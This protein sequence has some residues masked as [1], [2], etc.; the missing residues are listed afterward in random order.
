M[1]GLPPPLSLSPSIFRSPPVEF[2]S[3]KDLRRSRGLPRNSRFDSGRFLRANR[4]IEWD[5]SRVRLPPPGLRSLPL[6]L[7]F[8]GSLL[9]SD[10]CVNP[11]ERVD[12]RLANSRGERLRRASC[13]TGI[14]ARC[15]H[16]ALRDNARH[17][18]ES[19]SSDGLPAKPRIRAG[20]SGTASRRHRV[21][22]RAETRDAWLLDGS[23]S[24]TNA[25]DTVDRRRP[26]SLSLSHSF[27]ARLLRSAWPRRTINRVNEAIN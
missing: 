9:L 20:E 8:R 27:S 3:S 18:P 19:V 15:A 22:T 17:E 24:G 23:E 6:P 7:A 11:G 14:R 25:K 26:F 2:N 21:Q 12:P 1:R 4:K 10:V 13:S 16:C 5:L